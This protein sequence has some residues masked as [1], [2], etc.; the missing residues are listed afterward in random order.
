MDLADFSTEIF[1][2]DEWFAVENF[3]YNNVDF[4]WYI[5]VWL[6]ESDFFFTSINSFFVFQV[7][8][9]EDGL[10]NKPI[11]SPFV[12]SNAFSC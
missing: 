3:I 11:I 10:E 7:V 6:L 1:T 4:I 12:G 5:K 8:V 9:L 2:A